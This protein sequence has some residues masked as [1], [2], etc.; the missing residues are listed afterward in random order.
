MNTIEE[1]RSE[2][3]NVDDELLA[4][5]AK[6]KEIIRLIAAYKSEH[7]LDIVDSGREKQLLSRLMEEAELNGLDPEFINELYNLIIKNSRKEQ[8]KNIN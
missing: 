7:H 2:I 8:E 4:L 6:R 1:L 5:L 3:D